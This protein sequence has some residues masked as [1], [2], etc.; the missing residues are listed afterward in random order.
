MYNI[1]K[2]KSKYAGTSLKVNDSVEGEPIETKIVRMIEN[3]EQIK[4]S[5]PLIFTERKEG[6]LP[7]YNIRTD[8][9]AVAI[10]ALDVASKN[11]VAKRTL[12]QQAKEGMLKE[13][14]GEAEP[15]QTT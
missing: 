13:E 9:M 14:D 2:S 6:V 12:G 8:K 11:S 4:D 5:A 15:T 3:N 1:Q 10:D 7:A